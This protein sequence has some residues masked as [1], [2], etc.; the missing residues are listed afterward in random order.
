MIQENKVCSCTELVLL[1]FKFVFYKHFT[2]LTFILLLY[3]H[4][5]AQCS[6]VAHHF[7]SVAHNFASNTVG[8]KRF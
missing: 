3:L 6:I 5:Y 2:L 4:F 8:K 7:Y 1:A